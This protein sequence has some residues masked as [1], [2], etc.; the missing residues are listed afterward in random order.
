MPRRSA[1]GSAAAR[2]S[3]PRSDSSVRASHAPAS[4]R[5]QPS[6]AVSAE[7]SS[8]L[9]P[10]PGQQPHALQE[11]QAALLGLAPHALPVREHLAQPLAVQLDPLAAQAHQPAGGRQEL[12]HLGGRERVVAQRDGHREI[13][14][15]V[16]AECAR[17]LVA[18]AHGHLGPRRPPWAPPVRHAHDQAGRLEGGDGLQELVSLGRRPR[19]RLVDR[20][21]VDQ[22]GQPRHLLGG[23]L[24][25]HQQMQQRLTVACARRIPRAPAPAADAGPCHAAPAR[26]A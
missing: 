20:A 2:P 1:P 6:A 13:E 11:R 19:H 18:H 16:H 22:L 5:D 24:Q 7:A 15:R 10:A 25:R 26:T 14:Q 3:G 21:G 9:R 23:A 8:S 4:T 12:A 17:L